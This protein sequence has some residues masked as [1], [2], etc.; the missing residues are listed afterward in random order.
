MVSSNGVMNS[1]T[2]KVRPQTR[3][4]RDAAKATRKASAAATGQ[5]TTAC[6]A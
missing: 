6:S 4:Q 5:L 3:F 2:Q 1:Q